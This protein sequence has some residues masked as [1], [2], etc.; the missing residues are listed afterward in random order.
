MFLYVSRSIYVRAELSTSF[1]YCSRILTLSSFSNVMQSKRTLVV[2]LMV[3]FSCPW[4]AVN[5]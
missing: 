2:C 5:H 1:N 4:Y 3:T